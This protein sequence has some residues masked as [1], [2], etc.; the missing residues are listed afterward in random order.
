MKR[1][2]GAIMKRL[3]GGIMAFEFKSKCGD[4]VEFKTNC[5]HHILQTITNKKISTILKIF[6][7]ECCL[8]KHTEG[9][10]VGTKVYTEGCGLLSSINIIKRMVD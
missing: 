8:I 7:E 1:L 9:C 3:L 6:V 4:Q 10:S 2:L 5:K